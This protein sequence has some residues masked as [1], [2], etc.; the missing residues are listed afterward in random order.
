MATI[1]KI[2]FTNA[3][4]MREGSIINSR[5]LNLSQTS[6]DY[7]QTFDKRRAESIRGRP[8]PLRPGRVSEKQLNPIPPSLEPEVLLPGHGEPLIGKE[9]I[10]RK[11]TEYRDAIRY[12][13]DQT[14]KGLNEGKDV[15]TL[16]QEIRLPDHLRELPQALGRVSWTVRGIYEWYV[17]WFD[18]DVANVYDQPVS[19]IYP[20]L[21]ELAGGADPLA[22][23]AREMVRRG[24]AVKALH[25]TNVV[26]KNDPR[27]KEALEARLQALR[28]LLE[29]TGNYMETQ[30]LAAAIRQTQEA[31]NNKP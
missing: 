19:S 24:E 25:L 22:K 15:H 23:R 17:G 28:M 27:H 20:D 9:L 21:L 2:V 3:S 4:L 6:N 14:V 26:L 5:F 12:V 31:L 1:M 29:K 30:W 8:I 13:H 7:E 16:M 11:L 18:G 10:R